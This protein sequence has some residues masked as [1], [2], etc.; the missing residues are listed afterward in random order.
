MKHLIIVKFIDSSFVDKEY[1]NILNI[2]N[3]CL[4]IDG[5]NQIQLNKNIILRENRYDL[6]IEI[7]MDKDALNLYDE[8]I[9]HHEWKDK[10]SKY[11]K[12]KAII[13]LD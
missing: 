4:K 8:S 3:K 9:P 2:F 12:N 6:L 13:D 1:E 11:I 10:Y 7:D 5:I